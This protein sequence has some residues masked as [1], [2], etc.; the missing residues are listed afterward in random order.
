MKNIVSIYSVGIISMMLFSS[1]TTLFEVKSDPQQAD[2]FVLN[3]KKEKKVLGKTPLSIPDSELKKE[4]GTPTE[5]GEFFVVSVEKEGF[6][7]ETFNIPATKFGT[8]ITSL[9]VKLKPGEAPQELNMAKEVLDHMFLAQRL[10]LAQQYE[11]A[12]IELDKIITPFPKFSRALSMRA[13]IYYAQKNFTESMK[14][15]EE[16]IKYDPQMEEAV[17]MLA[18]VR[19]LQGLAPSDPNAKVKK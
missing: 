6:V 11:R 14:W 15:Y 4:L 3:E 9:N 13:S 1:C 12:Q 5:A 16:A 2:V 7:P 8:S 19:S 17:K 18:K 10:A